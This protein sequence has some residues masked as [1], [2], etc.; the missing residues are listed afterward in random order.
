MC[1]GTLADRETGR[2]RVGAGAGDG[3]VGASI[4]WL[5]CSFR[6]GRREDGVFARVSRTAF[7]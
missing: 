7:E 6:A 3:I 5:T 1:T 4:D 2:R